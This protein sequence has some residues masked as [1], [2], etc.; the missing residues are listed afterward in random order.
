M[1]PDEVQ[2]RVLS[3]LSAADLVTSVPLVC[4]QWHRLAR[5]PLLW[6][7]LHRRHFGSRPAKRSYKG[8]LATKE[9][10]YTVP[11]RAYMEYNE[12]L[13]D[14]MANLMELTRTGSR[15]DD[16]KQE[17]EKHRCREVLKMSVDHGLVA[18]VR[19][20]LEKIARLDQAS[21]QARSSFK[22]A[23]RPKPFIRPEDW[24]RTLASHLM[25]AFEHRRVEVAQV[26]LEHGAPLTD[27]DVMAAGFRSGVA[28]SALI[29][30]HVPHEDIRERMIEGIATSGASRLDGIA[31]CGRVDVMR[32][33]L[34]R[35]VITQKQYDDALGEG[36]VQAVDGWN[37]KPVQRLLDAGVSANLRT[38][39]TDKPILTKVIRWTIDCE[40]LEI[41]Q[42]L[43]AHGACFDPRRPGR[44][45]LTPLERA[46]RY[47][48]RRTVGWLLEIGAR[49]VLRMSMV[50]RNGKRPTRALRAC[51]GM[52][53]KDAARQPKYANAK[54][55]KYDFGNEEDYSDEDIGN[56][57][58]E[59]SE[60]DDDDD[61]D[62]DVAEDNAVEP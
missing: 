4:R 26:L 2:M 38:R 12:E 1:L 21:A 40:A 56:E 23:A 6:T 18:S 22:A 52:V 47:G 14:C 5:D 61:D 60:Y 29:L 35:G 13:V 8:G 55:W 53:A 37:L 24:S 10:P 32:L 54:T 48:R 25:T 57:E 39:W 50:M 33:L 20:S 27:S 3:E 43:V 28:A 19:E 45:H 36:L 62:D 16:F 34:A 58:D 7:L 17:P 11:W 59:Y 51:W 42:L 31:G 46:V 30:D 15:F 9:R 49:P 41:A 44:E